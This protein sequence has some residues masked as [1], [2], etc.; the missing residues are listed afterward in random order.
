M[1]KTLS[2]LRVDLSNRLGFGSQKGSGIIQAPMLESILK[3]AQ[4]EILSTFGSQIGSTYPATPFEKPNDL[5][6]VPEVP[7]VIKARLAAREHYSQPTAVDADKW[8]RW[9]AGVRGQ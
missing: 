8:N 6:S 2:Q 7:L 5:P 4:A 1:P 3:E 9:E